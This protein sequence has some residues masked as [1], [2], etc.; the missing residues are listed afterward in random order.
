MRADLGA[1]ESALP[2][3]LADESGELRRTGAEEGVSARELAPDGGE[4]VRVVVGCG[5]TEM[6]PESQIAA[7]EARLGRELQE[8]VSRPGARR[9]AAPARAVAE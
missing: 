8:Y 9:D 2:Q 5:G 6:L 1:D 4:R 3:E 7:L